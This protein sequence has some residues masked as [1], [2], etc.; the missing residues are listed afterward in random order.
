MVAQW[1]I[2]ERR[3]ATF[4]TGFRPERVEEAVPELK[5]IEPVPEVR[6]SPCRWFYVTS[7]LH[8]KRDD[9]APISSPSASEQPSR[10]RHPRVVA[11]GDDRVV[12]EPVKRGTDHVLAAL[13]SPLFWSVVE[14]SNA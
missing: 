5:T 11:K 2:N 10:A 7:L 8:A 4:L 6:A 3:E 12:N 13:P 1:L 9:G 14:L